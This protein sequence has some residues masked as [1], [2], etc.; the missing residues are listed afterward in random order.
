[1]SN[2]D[3]KVIETLQKEGRSFILALIIIAGYLTFFGTVMYQNPTNYE[4]WQTLN[5]TYGVIV[6]TVVGYYFGQKPVQQAIQSARE[7]KGKLVDE[8]SS[9]VSEIDDGLFYYKK[10]REFLREALEKLIAEYGEK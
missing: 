9:A 8:A 4:G 10:N 3:R 1:M 6:A 2:L 7:N 5:A